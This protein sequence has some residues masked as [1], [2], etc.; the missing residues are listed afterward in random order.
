MI[1]KCL[2][3]YRNFQKEDAY[4][5]LSVIFAISCGNGRF[6]F[7]NNQVDHF[8]NPTFYSNNYY[9]MAWDSASPYMMQ[10]LSVGYLVS[11]T[12]DLISSDKPNIELSSRLIPGFENAHT[13]YIKDY[14]ENNVSSSPLCYM[15]EHYY[16]PNQFKLNELRANDMFVS[17]AMIHAAHEAGYFVFISTINRKVT[18]GLDDHF[19]RIPEI[20][21]HIKQKLEPRLMVEKGYPVNKHGIIQSAYLLDDQYTLSTLNDIYG[22]PMFDDIN[23]ATSHDRIIQ[24]KSWYNQCVPDSQ[25][26]LG[27]I[28]DNHTIYNYS[29]TVRTLLFRE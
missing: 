20:R 21:H 28:E 15:L 14:F 22:N 4:G 10:P 8:I 19:L 24:G 12:F 16:P 5:G 23:Y 11:L 25:E 2:F 13:N 1:N 26:H 17:K 7:T 6:T 3:L 18:G 29:N 27:A 9:A